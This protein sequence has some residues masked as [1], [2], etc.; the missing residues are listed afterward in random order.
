MKSCKLFSKSTTLTVILFVVLGGKYPPSMMSSL[1]FKIEFC[2][3]IPQQKPTVVWCHYWFAQVRIVTCFL[4]YL[5]L[6]LEDRVPFTCSTLMH[7][8]IDQAWVNTARWWYYVYKWQALPLPASKVWNR[9]ELESWIYYDNFPSELMGSRQ[10]WLY[11]DE[12]TP[13]LIAWA[14]AGYTPRV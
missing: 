1:T 10:I 11:F 5:E 13:D 14:M 8:A 12:T 4:G 3:L 6:L 2:L 9:P 7:S